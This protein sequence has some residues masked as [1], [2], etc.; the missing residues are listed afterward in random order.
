VA[1]IHNI[2]L[3]ELIMLLTELQ[4]SGSALVDITVDADKPLVSFVPVPNPDKPKKKAV[5]KKKNPRRDSL[6]NLS[7]LQP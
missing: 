6:D 7:E 4:E 2:N 1:T 5:R 3:H